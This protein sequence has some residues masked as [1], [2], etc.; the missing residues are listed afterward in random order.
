MAKI[1]ETVTYSLLGAAGAVAGV[2]TP[3]TLCGGGSCT[4]CLR[5]AGLGIVLVILALSR[6]KGGMKHGLVEK[7]H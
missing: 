1:P 6:K 4:A 7:R 2:A 3:A 5:C